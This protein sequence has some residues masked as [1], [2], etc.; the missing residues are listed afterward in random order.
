MD[1]LSVSASMIAVITLTEQCAKAFSRLRNLCKT[2]P[3]RLHA[4][5]DEVT[6][7]NAVLADIAALLEERG[8]H[9]IPHDEQRSLAP[10]VTQLTENLTELRSIVD[11]VT[12]SCSQTRIPI[13]QA[14]AWSKVQEK[15]SNLQEDIK[16]AKSRLNVLLSASNSWVLNHQRNQSY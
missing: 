15:L 10:V 13:V 14:R 12:V 4:L 8:G 6:D 9:S 5:N 16:N 11:A 2:L 1:P 7:V 3:G